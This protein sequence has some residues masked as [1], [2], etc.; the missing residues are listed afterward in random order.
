MTLSNV[1]MPV[2]IFIPMKGVVGEQKT[3][4][5][6]HSVKELRSAGIS[7][8]VIVCRSSSLL[9]EATKRKLSAFCQVPADNVLSVHDVSNIYHV[10]LILADQGLHTLIREHLGLD[11]MCW[12]KHSPV[13]IKPILCNVYRQV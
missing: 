3:K 9:D 6:Q 1:S 4:P 2:L 7:P 5:T 10:P 11:G 13:V 8:D 12:I